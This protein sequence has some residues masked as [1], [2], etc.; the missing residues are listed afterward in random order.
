MKP[1]I[2]GVNWVDLAAYLKLTNDY[3]LPIPTRVQLLADYW[4]SDPGFP[5]PL[6]Q[7]RELIELQWLENA[8]TWLLKHLSAGGTDL[9]ARLPEERRREYKDL[10]ESLLAGED[11]RITDL[12]GWY[13]VT[14][15]QTHT[16]AGALLDWLYTFPVPGGEF[17]DDW[18]LPRPQNEGRAPAHH[19]GTD[20]FAPEGTP[21]ISPGDGVV[22]EQ[23]WNWLGGWTLT[24]ED[25][26]TGVQFYFAHLQGYAPD[27]VPD[28]RVEQGD[29]LGFVGSSGEGPEGTVDVIGEPHLHFGLRLPRGWANPYPYLV[30]W[31][32]GG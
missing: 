11:M 16:R 32:G 6:R 5:G 2:A 26:T 9:E 21:I 18:G 31:A 28:H 20:V 12:D 27:V 1:G 17:T 15:G 25:D 7:L 3:Q 23:A 19:Q 24:I 14:E 8:R 13:Q 22:V 4:W 10:R 30:K 29:V